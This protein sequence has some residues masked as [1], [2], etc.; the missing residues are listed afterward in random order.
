MLSAFNRDG[1]KRD[2]M[3]A[4]KR[5]ISKPRTTDTRAFRRVRKTNAPHPVP[6]C[7]LYARHFTRALIACEQDRQKRSR[8]PRCV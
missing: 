3:P 5:G 4:V 7:L 8:K 1:K 6:L 2:R